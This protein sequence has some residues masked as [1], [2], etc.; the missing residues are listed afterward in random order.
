VKGI[1]AAPFY[2]LNA[3]PTTIIFTM[4]GDVCTNQN[5]VWCIED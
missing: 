3:G 2:D 1:M 4:L 5:R